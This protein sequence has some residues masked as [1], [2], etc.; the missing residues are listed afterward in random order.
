LSP[1]PHPYFW[2]TKCRNKKYHPY[3]DLEFHVG[4]DASLITVAKFLVDGMGIKVLHEAF[5]N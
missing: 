2:S 5:E 3:T 4:V 1:H